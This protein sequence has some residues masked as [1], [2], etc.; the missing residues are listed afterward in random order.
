MKKKYYYLFGVRAD[1]ATSDTPGKL[2]LDFCI[3]YT[4]EEIS[5][6]ELAK[7]MAENEAIKT[8]KDEAVRACGLSKLFHE[9]NGASLR[10]GANML[11][12]HKVNSDFKM[13]REMLSIWVD[14][15]NFDEVAKQKLNES[16][17]RF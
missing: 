11:S 5:N 16:K 8:S 6:T 3:E 1:P 2:S 15:C 12:T 13:D 14:S 10:V 17:V 7:I 4:D 9:I